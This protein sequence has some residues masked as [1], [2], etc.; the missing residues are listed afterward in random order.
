MEL[1]QH[2]IE[3]NW[4]AMCDLIASNELTCTQPAYTIQ[5]SIAPATEHSS[6]AAPTADNV[7]VAPLSTTSLVPSPESSHANIS[8]VSIKSLINTNNDCEIVECSV[9][10]LPPRS[11]CGKPPNRYSLELATKVKYPIAHYMSTH[12]LSEACQ[13][14]VNQMCMAVTPSKVQDV[15]SDS[16]WATAMTEEMQA[17]EKS[18]TWKLVQLPERKKL[19][20]CIWVYT[21][22]HKPYAF[23]DRYKA[24]L[25]ARDFTKTYGIDYQETFALMA[26]I[27]TIRV[28]LSLA[29]NFN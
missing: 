14:F 6:T 12:G 21:I 13:A 2:N 16:K 9:Y 5:A 23:I 17:L 24:R 27:K 10:Q 11:N 3:G 25:V 20:G 15:L 4:L 28:L 22:K 1:F 26:K 7:D 18:Q 19:V 29:T 8:K